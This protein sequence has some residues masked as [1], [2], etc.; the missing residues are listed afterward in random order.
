MARIGTG[1][2]LYPW[3]GSRGADMGEQPTDED[4]RVR[5]QG[6]HE[7]G[8][9]TLPGLRRGHWVLLIEFAAQSGLI[10][11]CHRGVISPK[12]HTRGALL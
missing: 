11:M 7:D 3:G 5:T 1:D 8:T 10:R 4:Q 9:A 12:N 2:L 6:E